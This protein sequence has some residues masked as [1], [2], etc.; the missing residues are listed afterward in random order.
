MSAEMKAYF[1]TKQLAKKAGDRLGIN[2]KVS[3]PRPVRPWQGRSW[4]IE[5]TLPASSMSMFPN[6]E[7]SNQVVGAVLMFDGVVHTQDQP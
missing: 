6:P 5:I 4:L 1:P 7:L 2:F 3:E